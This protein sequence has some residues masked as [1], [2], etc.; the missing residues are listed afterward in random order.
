MALPAAG[1]PSEAVW[2][3][4]EKDALGIATRMARS[5][6]VCAVENIRCNPSRQSLTSH[7]ETSVTLE[8]EI[9]M[10]YCSR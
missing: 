3:E 5:T 4:L 8:C 9:T 10:W 7:G 6:E 1:E 2:Q